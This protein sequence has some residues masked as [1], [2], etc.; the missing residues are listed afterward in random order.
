[1]SPM[2][3][4]LVH[5][6]LHVPDL[7]KGR[8]FFSSLLGWE[9]DDGEHPVATNLWRTGGLA[10]GSAPI[11]CYLWSDDVEETV[12]KVRA[13]GGSSDGVEEGPSGKWAMCHDTEGTAFSVSWLIPEFRASEES[14]GAG[15][16]ELAYWV[17]PVVDM[18]RARKFYGEVF[19]WTFAPGEEY[20]HVTNL[21]TA[22]GLA[23]MEGTSPKC[24]FRVADME[25]SLAEVVRLGGVAGEA[26]SSES[27]L[28]ASCQ[29]NQGVA[30]DLWQP[31]AGILA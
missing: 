26:T 7:A 27:G 2:P 20:A 5:F 13:E 15:A 12:S 11:T 19:G 9:L 31:T 6:T 10:Q 30:F 17:Q 28:S 18:A 8:T 1:M 24:W 22:C 25:G 23:K 4:E 29:D 21:K 16:G 3:G 14:P